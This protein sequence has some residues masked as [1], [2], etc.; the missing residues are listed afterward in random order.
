MLCLV[1]V[2]GIYPTL[3]VQDIRSTGSGETYSK[4]QLWKLFSLDRLVCCS[5]L[6]HGAGRKGVVLS[7]T[8]SYYREVYNR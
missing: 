3:A 6:C 4:V 1:T 2:R 7:M 8:L 5:V